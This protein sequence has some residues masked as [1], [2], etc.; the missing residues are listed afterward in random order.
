[1]EIGYHILSAMVAY[2]LGSVPT[3]YLVARHSGN[4]D[5]LQYGSGKTGA[6][7]VLRAVG[8]KA[9][10]AVLLG[11]YAKGIV[12]ILVARLIT[13]GDPVA[14]LLAGLAAIAGHNYSPFLRFKGGRGV[15]TGVGTLSVIAPAAMLVAALL[16][17]STIYLTR[18]VSLGSILG[19]VSAPICILVLVLAFHQPP[20]H[21]LYGL[22]GAAFVVVGH[23]DNIGRLL[24]GTERKLGERVG[25]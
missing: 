4:V 17:A 5:L 2:L 23:H 15:S 14:D 16:F 18:Y 12:A 1:M 13:G 20:M 6:T 3:G 9:A 11:D 25:S 22:V 8:K 24:R 21:L 7:N 10:A 19:A